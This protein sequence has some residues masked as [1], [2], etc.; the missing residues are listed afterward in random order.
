MTAWRT[1]AQGPPPSRTALEET[2]GSQGLAPR[3][4]SNDSNYRYGYHEHH[5]H[6]VLYCVSGSIVFHT[7]AGDFALSPG[8]RLDVEAGTSHAATVGPE[9]VTCVEAGA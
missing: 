1:P 2:L 9:G 3:W 8:D 7:E 4:W 6:K 5:Y